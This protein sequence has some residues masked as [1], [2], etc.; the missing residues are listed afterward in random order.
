M[1]I[2]SEIW[3]WGEVVMETATYY[4]VRWDSDPWCLEQV[5]KED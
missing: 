1:K 4:V 2:Y 3:G 5:P